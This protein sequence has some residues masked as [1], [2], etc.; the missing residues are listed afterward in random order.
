MK[1]PKCGNELRESKKTPGYF[2]CDSCKKKFSQETLDR[3]QSARPVRRKKPAP[4][5]PEEPDETTQTETNQTEEIQAEEAQTSMT[6]R[7]CFGRICSGR[8]F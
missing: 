6:R 3:F 5:K 4:V 2:L 8:I 7:N 1:C